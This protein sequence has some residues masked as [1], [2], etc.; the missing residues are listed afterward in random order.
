MQGTA[1]AVNKAV[2]DIENRG[3]GGLTPLSSTSFTRASAA[4][5]FF[6]Y[7]SAR[8]ALSFCDI[9]MNPLGR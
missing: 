7:V 9:W 2:I 6:L 3:D 1:D 5:A 8:L 4:C